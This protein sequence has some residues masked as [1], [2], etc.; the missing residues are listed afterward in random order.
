MN[1][2]LDEELP[3]EFD[4]R[5]KTAGDVVETF[6]GD[7]ECTSI[8]AN[9]QAA[10]K[11]ERIAKVVSLAR[12]HPEVYVERFPDA[13]AREFAERSALLDIALRLRSTE[14]YVRGVLFTAEQAMA[15]LPNLWREARDGFAPMYLAE[16]TVGALARVRARADATDEE[17]AAQR[18]AYRRIDEAAAEW[19]VSCSPATFR[20]RLKTLVDRLD[21]SDRSEQHALAMADRRV[22]LQEQEHGMSVLGAVLPTMQ[23]R[24]ALRRLT[25]TAKHMAK[26]RR[27]GRTRDQIRADLF[28]DWLCG[29][30]T[31]RAVKTKV[32]VTIPVQMLTEGG[33]SG[34]GSIAAVDPDA[35]EIL[36]TEQ[37][38]M[39]GCGPI[40]PLTAKQIFLDAKAFR[41]VIT[42]PVRSVVLDMD[43]RTYRPT[44]A[45]RDWLVLQ[46]G[47]CARDGCERLAADSDV[48]HRRAWAAGGATNLDNLAPLCPRDHTHRHKT[49]ATYRSRPDGSVQVTTPT[50]FRTTAPPGPAAGARR[51]AAPENNDPERRRTSD[52]VPM[53]AFDPVQLAADLAE[54]AVHPAPF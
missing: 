54:L 43:R 52:P 45:Q 28:G 17:L 6:L 38:Q 3:G 49:R 10:L 33:A 40:D 25:A 26:D 46:H 12:E 7:L 51:K 34:A 39:V 8:E 23:A 32:Y 53:R 22:F 27:E 31:D 42:D 37:A 9:R 2:W 18:E 30:G 20:R 48:D 44:K 36:A 1:G 15:F 11:A 21:P 35:A 24:A 50:G 4:T 13:E 5:P 14:D 41:R 29:V 19:A 16:C 47:T